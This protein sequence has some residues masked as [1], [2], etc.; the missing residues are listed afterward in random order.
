M[1]KLFLS[2]LMTTILAVPGVVN[3]AVDVA[4]ETELENAIKNGE[5][6]INLTGD[7]TLTTNEETHAVRT[8]GLNVEGEGVITI[9]GNG[10]AINTD[11]VVAMEVRAKTGKTLKLVLK[12]IT[13]VGKERAIDTRTEGITL[14][15]NKTNLSVTKY[16][17][18]QA[19]T[20]GGSV[21][22]ITV[23][24]NEGSVIDGGQAGYGIVTFNP[25]NMT[26]KDSTV[27]GYAALYMKEADGS[28]G[29][30]GSVVTIENSTIEGNSKYSGYSDNFGAIVLS[31][32]NIKINIKDSTV[33]AVN[34]GTA[35]Q[36]PFV[37][38]ENVTNVAENE[39]V[40]ITVEGKS[41]FIM[42]TQIDDESLVLNYDNTKM[43]V[44]VKAGV[45]SNVQIEEEYL[46]ENTLVVVDPTTGEVTV[47]AKDN[48][49]EEDTNKEEN[50]N[51]TTDK[52]E[53]FTNPDTA[54]NIL[55]YITLALISVLSIS[56]LIIYKKRFN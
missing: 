16:G 5:T 29:S 48:N 7:I 41:E 50:N 38:D 21:G 55:T 23:D 4:S 19:L 10:Y 11:L 31:D 22:P 53:G 30:N 37:L 52:N 44:A 6:E 32:K 40:S 46:D 15:L 13:I 14:E 9:N 18:Y 3:A 1:K 24:I 43:N 56:G 26:I 54:D 12:D 35:Y 49:L 42:D 27:K 33:K 20:I 25:V 45:K 39:K 34:T 8:V 51:Q 28:Q 47:V 36:V 17:N 2:I